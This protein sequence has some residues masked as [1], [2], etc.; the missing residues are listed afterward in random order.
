MKILERYILKENLQP[1]LLSL[2]VITF[3]ILTN[4]I[5]EL[6][7]LIIEKKLDFFTVVSIF[8]LSLPY[9][10]A[11]SIPMSVLVASILSFG[12]LSL[13]NEVI[14]FK[15]CGINIYTLMRPTVIAAL[16][17]SVF[18]I[19]FNNQILPNTN[20]KLKNLMIKAH[21][22]R[23]ITDIKTG[24]FN[25]VKKFTIYVKENTGKEMRGLVIYNRENSKYPATITAE[26]GKINLSNG[27]N[28]IKLELFNGE[29]HERNKKK[30]TTYETK[31]F[32][33]FVLYRHDL[34]YKVNETSSEYRSDR[35]LSSKAM[36][37]KINRH[38]RKIEDLNREITKFNEK[39]KRSEAKET[40]DKTRKK[41]L[42][43]YKNTVSMN[44]SKIAD[45][46]RKILAYEVEIQK[47]YSI[48]FACLVFVL[49]GAPVGMMTRTSSVGMA[50]TV[51][52][53]VFV[54][55]YSALVGGEELADKGYVSPFI[56]MW[57]AN[58]VFAI[59]G[60]YLIVSSVKETKFINL[61]PIKNKIAKLLKL[62]RNEIT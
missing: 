30:P 61:K 32:K 52:S 4:R 13:D 45:L 2:M 37:E 29:M 21:Y 3:L 8:S 5:I 35:E 59:V 14:A 12:R 31:R 58:F 43:K 51:S 56:A 11:L 15:S 54:I 42:K 50:F 7:N 16:L 34:G 48:A 1:F 24:I 44:K 62:R 47:K 60:I 39:I 20:H 19:Y 36:K 41:R 22:R 57:I 9:M 38:E 55:Y 18:M 28:S 40:L 27:G 23:P 46:N 6:L 49:V 25:T 33:K 10:L 17:L 53:L 26:R